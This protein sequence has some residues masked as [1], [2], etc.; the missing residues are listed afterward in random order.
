MTVSPG[1][2][3]T[4]RS[5]RLA[6]VAGAV[7]V[8]LVLAGDDSCTKLPT[9]TRDLANPAAATRALD[10]GDDMPRFDAARALLPTGE[11]CGEGGRV[12]AISCSTS[13]AA[14]PGSCR[15]AGLG[16]PSAVELGFRPGAGV[17][18]VG[19]I[20]VPAGGRR[21]D[22]RAGGPVLGRSPVAHGREGWRV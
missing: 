1:S 4:G 10:P 16:T 19:E 13:S 8:P 15:T 20:A 7:A 11:L 5:P 21:A 12:L 6:L 18:A 2:G 9:M 22:V 17:V 14:G 3:G